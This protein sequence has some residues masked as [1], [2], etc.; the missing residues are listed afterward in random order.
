VKRSQHLLTDNFL[1]TPERR[2]FAYR[3]G[4]C[5][6]ENLG[7]SL[8]PLTGKKTRSYTPNFIQVIVSK[9]TLARKKKLA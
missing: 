4:K 2:T 6:T 3:S 8:R 1:N 9:Y 7:T 5:S